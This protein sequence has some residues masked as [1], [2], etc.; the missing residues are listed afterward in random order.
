MATPTVPS[1][2]AKLITRGTL[3]PGMMI[4]TYWLRIHDVGAVERAAETKL[5]DLIP[6]HESTPCLDYTQ[7]QARSDSSMV[8]QEKD[9]SVEIYSRTPQLR[10][11]SGFATLKG[12]LK[13]LSCWKAT[14]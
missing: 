6:L 3:S 4:A 11:R 7:M 5:G 13:S 9:V 12:L 10:K 8:S 2:I 14:S 1:I